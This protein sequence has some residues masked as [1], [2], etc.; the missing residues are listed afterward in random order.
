MEVQ[1]CIVLS[2]KFIPCF[3]SPNR[4]KVTLKH[5]LVV[6][7]GKGLYKVIG[8]FRIVLQYQTHPPFLG[9]VRFYPSLQSTKDGSK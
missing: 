6:N 8:Q 5:R 1:F 9:H 4:M 2:M 7:Q 3:C